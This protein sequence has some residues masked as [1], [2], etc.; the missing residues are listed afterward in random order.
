[1]EGP[2]STGFHLPRM[3][4]TPFVGVK[5]MPMD[6]PISTI[7]GSSEKVHTNNPLQGLLQPAN[8]TRM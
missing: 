6:L 5:K 7:S 3:L 4:A 1:M 2:E 8:L